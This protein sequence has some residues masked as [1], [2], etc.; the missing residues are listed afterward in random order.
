LRL[1][2]VFNPHAA[3]GRAA[4]LLPRVAAAL[5]QFADIDVRQT[6][7][8]GDAVEQVGVAP[9]DAYDGVIAAGGDGTLFEVLN[10]LYRHAP[11]RRV[12]LGLLPVGTGNAFARDLGLLP[13]DWEKGVALIGAR[14]LRR[15]DVG[16]VQCGPANAPEPAFHFLNIV[17]AGLPVDAMRAAERIKFVGSAAYS[18]ATFW[19]AL[20]LKTYPLAIELDGERIEQDALFVEISNTRY[21]GTSFLIAPAAR[22][23]DGLLDVTLVCRLSRRRLLRLF[24]TIYRGAHVAY[25]EVVTRRARSIRLLGPSGLALAPDG[26]FQGHTPATVTCLQG[27]LEIFAPA[28]R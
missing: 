6:A 2:L 24:P 16:R 13:G 21:T 22:F 4:S 20:L 18:L 15:V 10:G 17:G 9:L 11:E 25:E 8:P 19:R 12:P 3:F 27:D 14:Q 28:N 26:E 5:E 7:G 1:L 23:D